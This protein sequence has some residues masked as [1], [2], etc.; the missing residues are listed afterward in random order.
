MKI[1]FAIKDLNNSKGGAERVLA[2]I[3]SGLARLGH[4]VTILSYDK[5]GGQ[6]YYF[7]DEKIKR[8]SLGIGN[9]QDH[10]GFNETIGRIKALRLVL[11]VRQPDV[12]IPF[13]HSMF[14]PMSIAAF[15][16]GIPVIASEHIV[17]MHYR[18][19]PIQFILMFLSSFLV[20]RFTVLSP[21][22]RASYP[23]LI[24]RK[25]IVIPNPVEAPE[26]LKLNKTSN[27]Y[28]LLNVGRL[29]G[30]KDQKTLIRAFANLAADFPDWDVKIFGEGPLKMFLHN[31][32]KK[33]DL[34]ERILLMGTT[35]NI[36]QQYM[37]ADIFV[38]SSKYE[39]FGL[40][41]AE[42]MSYGVPCIGF[43][44]CPGTNELIK[45][46]KNGLLVSKYKKNRVVVLEDGL[47]SLMTNKDLRILLGA[48]A[49]TAV[50]KYH[51]EIIVKQWE[52]ILEES[53]KVNT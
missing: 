45:H 33:H 48:N 3:A 53:T 9:S 39:S 1:L 38:M 26:N 50:S 29:E 20:K 36:G 19:R 17:P 42:A 22:V 49:K 2:T 43:L 28:T 46:K 34:E 11:K 24:R 35:P 25:M 18:K 27:K 30:Q 7:L 51:P 8:L 12:V 32:I 14:I 37:N 47:R 10:A 6:S 41:T 21:S 44:E 4:D 15:G 23:W 52:H 16:C 13:M 40:A 5:L 31:L